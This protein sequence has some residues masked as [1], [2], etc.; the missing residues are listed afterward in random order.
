[1]AENGPSG[2]AEQEGVLT[3]PTQAVILAGGRGTRLAPLTDSMPKPMVPFH[4]RPFLAY[5][6]EHLR[7]Q[8]FTRVL[9]L[10]GYRAQQIQDYFTDGQQFGVQIDYS[11]TPEEDETGT[12]VRKARALLDPIFLLMYGD[13]YWPMP[14]AAMWDR[15]KRHDVAAMLTVY[16]NQDGFSR[17]NIQLDADG[18]IRLY[19]KSRTAE[20]LKGVDLGFMILCKEVVDLLADGNISF[21]A[22]LYPQLAKRGQLLAFITEHRYY[23]ITSPGKL[24]VMEQ[25][26]ARRPAVLLDRDGVLNRKMPRAHYV[27]SWQDWQWLPG[28]LSALRR[29][30]VAGYRVIVVTNQAGVARGAMS[31]ADLQAIHAR[32][33]QEVEAAGGK[34]DAIYTCPHG[35]DEGC[36]CRKPKPGMLLQAQRD[37]HL[38]LSRVWYVGDDERDGLAADA[39]GCRF[40]MVTEHSS[41][42]QVLD[43]IL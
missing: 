5:L 11:V 18:M 12:R 1:M 13:N 34:I 37:F 26:L 19:D 22:T 20:G 24:P 38:D 10:L 39:A 33:Q 14:F 15:F 29:L 17:D 21:E 25:F 36:A 8:G 31:E 2:S 35:W 27:C 30:Q 9:L 7:E 28:A 23:S 3:R 42:E 40:A 43:T 32:M 16:G 41:L 6:I 4:G